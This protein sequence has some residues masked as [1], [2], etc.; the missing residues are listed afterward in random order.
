MPSDLLAGL[1]V[2]AYGRQYRIELENGEILPCCTRGK[3][4][5][6]VCGDRVRVRE[7]K[8]GQARQGVIE[9]VAERKNLFYRSNA[10]RQKLIA[11]NVDQ[12]LLVVAAMP[13]FST[14]LL[15]RC[16]IAARQQ[17]IESLILLNKRDLADRLPAARESLASLRETGAVILEIAAREAEPTA[18]LL[19]PYLAGK[20]T[21]LAG[22]SGMGK[23][24]L[25]N[26]LLPWAR[27]ATGEI[28]TAL[29]SGKHTTTS[30]CLYRL[31]GS[32]DAGCLIDSPG[33]QEFGIAHLS[34]A[35]LEAAFPEFH[36]YLGHCRFRN[37]RHRQEPGCALSAAASA[38]ALPPARL[39]LFQRLAEEVR[40]GD[41]G[42]GIRNQESGIR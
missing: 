14:D 2:A 12:V 37:C 20:T 24:T 4:S 35:D 21:L 29:D 41:R 36:P 33:L 11:A 23:S 13:A 18:A 8:T 1:V 3:K 22:Q 40:G 17:G 30:A 28:S 19:A 31:A 39:E 42:P 10:F 7:E 38:G 25:I 15:E 27:A 6:A 34:L 26:A 32:T 9:S 5:E 16:R